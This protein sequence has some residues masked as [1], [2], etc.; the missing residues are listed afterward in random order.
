MR[1]CIKSALKKAKQ[2]QRHIHKYIYT[3]TCHAQT[4]IYRSTDQSL[5]HKLLGELI[6]NSNLIFIIPF[7][8]VMDNSG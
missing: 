5:I 4:H 1:T 2:V 7:T 3:N 8:K 6:L